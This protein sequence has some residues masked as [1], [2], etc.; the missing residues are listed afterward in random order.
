MLKKKTMRKK[1]F[2][3]KNKKSVYGM[4]SQASGSQYMSKASNYNRK[5]SQRSI[6]V[7]SNAPTVE[8]ALE[9]GKENS[10]MSELQSEFQTSL[11]IKNHHV[12]FLQG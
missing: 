12:N 11:K 10:D 8:K 6:S 7:N 3:S 2:M 4:K 1:D 9:E 5:D